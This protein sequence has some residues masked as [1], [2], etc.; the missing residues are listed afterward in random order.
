MAWYYQTAPHDTHDW[1]SAATPVLVDGMFKGRMR[2]MAMH[3]GR[4][5]YF[6]V[7]NRT[8]GEHLLTSAFSDT[9]NWAKGL[10]QEGPAHP[11]S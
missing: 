7:V 6:Y 2:K 8:T 9:V 10:Q 3:A 11:H 4:N 5:G 1:D